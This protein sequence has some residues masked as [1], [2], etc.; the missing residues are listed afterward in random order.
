MH[1]AIPFHTVN[2]SILCKNLVISSNE[3]SNF[4]II[5]FAVMVLAN[6]PMYSSISAR[7]PH[8]RLESTLDGEMTFHKSFVNISFLIL[9]W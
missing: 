5:F 8:L 6:N 4:F 3:S 7:Y 1:E 2:S 9:P